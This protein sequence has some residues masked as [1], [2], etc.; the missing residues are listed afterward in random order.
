MAEHSEKERVIERK[1][2]RN[3]SAQNDSDTRDTD[4]YRGIRTNVHWETFLF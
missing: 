4:C 1:R 2:L 3:K